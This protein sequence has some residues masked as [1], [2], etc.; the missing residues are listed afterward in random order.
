M[1]GVKGRPIATGLAILLTVIGFAWPLAKTPF[2]PEH[3]ADVLERLPMALG[4]DAGELRRLRDRLARAPTDVA[5]A[6]AVAGGYIEFGQ[7]QTDP[8]YYGYAQAALAPWWGL[9]NPPPEVLLL[10]A[11]IRQ[12]RHEFAPALQDLS[13]LLEKAPR[14]PQARLMQAVILIVRGD[15]GAAWQACEALARLRRAFLAFSCMGSVASL[16]GQAEGGYGLLV[17][18]KEQ[19]HGAAPAEQV[20]LETLLGKTAERMGDRQRAEAHFQEGRRLGPHDAYLLGAYADF[21]LDQGRAGDAV[22][23]L[24]DETRVDGLLLRLT[25]A[26][27]AIGA[28]GRDAHIEELRA[29]FAASRQRGDSLHQG[30]EARFVLH[31]TGRPQA[32]LTLAQA[33]WA[34]QREPGDARILLEAALTA[35]DA[36]AARPALDWMAET[37]IEDVTLRQLARRLADAS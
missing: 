12:S 30:E 21:L 11:A 3:D 13:R 19:S 14:D 15:Y 34:V 10:R 8:R 5:Q 33:N 37:G 1:Q 26:E 24:R 23:L 25:L 27:R 16:S 31:L 28:S 9:S 2:I 22:T 36:A 17:L 4:G 29:R 18:A 32:A 6:V 7:I 35:G 20:R